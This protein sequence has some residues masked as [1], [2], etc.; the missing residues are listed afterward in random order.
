[1]GQ[2]NVEG[3]AIERVT[4]AKW[5]GANRLDARTS[6]V[7]EHPGGTMSIP[8]GE[9]VLREIDLTGGY[10]CLAGPITD[11]QTGQPV[12]QAEWLLSISPDKPCSLKIGAPLKP[13]VAVYRQGRVL[14]LVYLLRDAGGRRYA[15]EKH[16]KPPRFTVSSGGRVVGSGMFAYS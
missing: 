1:M 4:L 14:E 15:T 12:K 7:L 3:D 11:G 2:L 9:Y 10:H 8:A 5:M 6:I 16:E 13:E